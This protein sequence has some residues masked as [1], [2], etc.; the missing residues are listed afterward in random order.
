MRFEPT[1]LAGLLVVRPDRRPDER[2]YFAR[3]WCRDEFAKAGLDFAPTQASVSYNRLAGTLRGMHW[4]AEPHGETKLVS[5]A[6]GRLFDVA[7]DLR[8]GSATRHRWFGLELSVDEPAALLIPRGFAHGFITLSD[9]TEVSY[10][11]DTPY[12][13]DSARGAAWN[14]PLLAIAW[15]RSPA[16]I[17][18]R[19]RAWP[20]LAP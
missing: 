19:D 2:G 8:E 7:V 3:L 1:G 9:D 4:Q 18:A 14:D 10:L 5:A 17:G 6:R 11:I 16:V 20:R 15:P 13:A 12:H